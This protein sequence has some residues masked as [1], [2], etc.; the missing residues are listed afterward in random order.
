MPLHWQ[1]PTKSE[2]GHTLAQVKRLFP[3]ALAAMAIAVVVAWA[4]WGRESSTNEPT[5][6]PTRP[7]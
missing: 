4:K 2:T 1:V 7:S 3:S 5:W 6:R